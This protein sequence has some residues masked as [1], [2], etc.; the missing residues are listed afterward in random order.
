VFG[1]KAFKP[2]SDWLSFLEMLAGQAAISIESGRLFE[3]LQIMNT[4]L[5]LS[6]DATLEGWA[7][8]LELRDAETEGHSRRVMRMTLRLARA[9]DFSDET[10]VQ[11]RRG[12]LMHDIGKMG[13]PDS[14]LL[15]PG[16]LTEE[17]WAVMRKHPVFAHQLMSGVSYLNPAM[18]I[19]YCHHEKW[20]GSGYPQ[21]LK[22]QQIPLAARIFALV[23]VW[24]ALTNERPYRKAWT[25]EKTA[26]YIREQS[27][28][29]FDPQVLE[30]CLPIILENE[31]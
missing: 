4:N 31:A 15:K 7:K 22:G 30:V 20:D 8:A 6:Y 27:G 26:A 23:D 16:K 11:V 13:V 10:L 19:P 29:H 1:R 2:T 12:A 21:G 28:I 25:P 24:D 9:M 14:I 18:D 17:E 3:D 5:A